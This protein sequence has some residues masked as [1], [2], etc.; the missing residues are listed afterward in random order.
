MVARGHGTHELLVVLPRGALG[1]PL[2]DEDLIKQLPPG[3]ELHDDV[4]RLRGLHALDEPNHVFV[5]HPF[6]HLDLFLDI[7]PNVVLRD[8]GLGDDLHG[9]GE[10]GAG[11]GDRVDLAEAPDPEETAPLVVGVEQGGG[12]GGRGGVHGGWVHGG[13]VHGGLKLF[14]SFIEVFL[15]GF[16]V[17]KY[18]F[19]PFLKVFKWF[20]ALF[21]GFHSLL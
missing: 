10:A 11:V 13:W 3:G 19:E 8:E 20:S 9:V 4:H 1:E 7:T 14:Y 5:S 12:G 2:G 15:K 18:F 16:D 17:F 6:E 21:L